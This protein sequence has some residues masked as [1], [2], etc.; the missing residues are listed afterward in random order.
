MLNTSAAQENSWNFIATGTGNSE[1]TGALLLRDATKTRMIVAP[2][3]EIKTSGGLVIDTDLQNNS[4]GV[5]IL[6]FGSSTS[7]EGIGS[8]RQVTNNNYGLDFYTD[9]TVRMSITNWGGVGIGTLFPANYLDINGNMAIGSAYAEN[10]TAPA[11]GAIIQG[12]VGIGKAN[13]TTKLDVNGTTKTT[14]FQLTNGASNNYILKS[15][16]NG[17]ASWVAPTTLSIT[18]TD[19]K[20]ASTTNR[21]IP[22]WNGTALIDGAIY[23]DGNNIGIGTIT[24]AGRFEAQV[25]AGRFF[26]PNWGV[27]A[28][29]NTTVLGNYNSLSSAGA[30]ARFSNTTANFSDIGQDT[31]GNFVVEQNDNTK[32]A[33]APNGNVGIGTSTPTDKL[34]LVGNLKIDAGRIPFINTGQSI[35]LG[36]GAGQNDDFNDHYNIAIGRDALVTNVTGSNNL[37]IGRD[38]LALTTT[39]NNLGIGWAAGQ[40]M[41]GTQNTAVGFFAGR[42]AGHGNTILGVNAYASANSTGANNTIIGTYAGQNNNGNGNVFLGI[43]AGQNATGNNK[44]FIHNSNSATPLIY[45][46]FDNQIL[47]ING[48]LGIGTTTPAEK[49]DVIG[50]TK[51]TSL[52]I[53]TGAANNYVLKSDANGNAN[54]ADLNTLENDPKVGNLTNNYI[55]RW[56]SS[57]STLQ[58]SQ[59][60]EDNQAVGIG[61]TSMSQA[62][63]V[64]SGYRT[65]GMGV[66]F[67]YLNNAGNTGVDLGTFNY[68]IYATHRIAASE[69]NAF[70]DKRIKNIIGIS[71]SEKD[72]D[73]LSKIKITD[74]KMIDTI[75]KGNKIYKKVIAQELAEVLPSAVSKM[76]DVVPNIYQLSSIKNGFIVLKNNNLKK[77][78]RVKLIFGENQEILTIKETTNEG[79]FVEKNI[80]DGAIF[81][82]GKE[83]SDFH[84]VDYEALTTLNISATQAL[85][86]KINELENQ[87]KKQNDDFSA[88]LSTIE[89]MLRMT[90]KK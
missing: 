87:V 69:F 32:F 36:E 41:S 73:L 25:T 24:P 78:E 34:H 21:K 44:L 39:D 23:D 42:F 9:N 82:Y 37:A 53:T 90:A 76:T 63:L 66:P 29:A 33:I 77:G 55:P 47:N 65:N 72:L 38:A 84:T 15:D 57:S 71:D 56:N 48:K 30:Q 31:N 86:K 12:N 40:Q 6:R 18:E 74:Y 85:L 19:P 3:G 49:L 83:V 11:N 10:E 75:S 67:G 35:F 54:W 45:G 46:E 59:I 58:N 89:E 28:G 88:R 26:V 14:N 16:A 4:D 60:Y 27:G 5:N 79:F 13:P 81:V 61:T 20:V 51:T 43:M 2:T 1:G 22:R 52:Q 7:G 64:V 17:N 70:S 50:K 8:S 62:K 68:S 80:A